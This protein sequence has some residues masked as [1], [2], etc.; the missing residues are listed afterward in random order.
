M[1]ICYVIASKNFPETSISVVLGEIVIS[2]IREPLLSDRVTEN[3][4]LA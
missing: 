4:L 2:I 1:R 3:E